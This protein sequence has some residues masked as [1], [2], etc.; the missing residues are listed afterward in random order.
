MNKQQRDAVVKKLDSGGHQSL[1]SIVS[2]LRARVEESA[3]G[4]MTVT[5]ALSSHMPA[6]DPSLRA[7]VEAVLIRD[8]TGPRAGERPPDFN[9]KRLGAND[10]VRLSSFQGVRP[11]AFAFGS[12]T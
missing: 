12:Y 2:D 11:V 7:A 1:R 3:G 8:Q 10:R 5:E 6:A 9:L 4:R